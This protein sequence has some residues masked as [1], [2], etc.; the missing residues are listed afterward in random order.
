MIGGIRE[1]RTKDLLVDV[2]CAMKDRGRLDSAFR[3]VVGETG[4]VRHLVPTVEVKILGIDPTRKAKEVA[5]AVQSCLKEETASE[6]KVSVTKKPFRGTRKAFVRLEEA[7]ALKLLK[8]TYINI[9]WVCCRIRKKTE[10]NRCY[11]CLGFGHM[12]VDC[13]GPDRSR[14]CWRC[15][16]EGRVAGSCPGKP[17]CHLFVA[18]VDKPRNDH[19]PETVRC[20]A[21]REAVPNRKP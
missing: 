4:S 6:V 20:A 11:H 1:T 18:R 16:E 5:E 7:R 12:A 8:M 15:S 9:G 10:R 14:S 21:F 13:L 19:I 17:R 2:K 3:Y